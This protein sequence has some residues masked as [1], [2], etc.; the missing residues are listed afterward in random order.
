MGP[1]P[2]YPATIVTTD[3]RLGMRLKGLPSIVSRSCCGKQTLAVRLGG[4]DE[5]VFEHPNPRELVR[6]R[7]GHQPERSID[8]AASLLKKGCSPTYRASHKVCALDNDLLD[9]SATDRSGS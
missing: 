5:P 1:D 4:I 7:V 9:K 8:P 3:L 6:L 2:N